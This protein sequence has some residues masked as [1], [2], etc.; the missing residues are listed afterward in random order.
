LAGKVGKL[1][2]I[3]YPDL[4]DDAP[5]AT[6]SKR[7][8]DVMISQT[9]TNGKV[10]YES[11]A[12]EKKPITKEEREAFEE[13]VADHNIGKMAK[14]AV[15]PRAALME[16]LARRGVEGFTVSKASSAAK[17]RN[18]EDY[19]SAPDDEDPVA[20]PAKKAVAKAAPAKRASLTGDEDEEDAPP[21]RKPARKTV[22]D[23]EDDEAPPSRRY[24]TADADDAP[25]D[26]E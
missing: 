15:Q 25:D 9:N 8:F 18:Y 22:L 21:A 12:G 23:E 5:D 1:S 17:K 13:Y 3:A 20:P 11:H 14:T 19:D 16:A 6:D 26:E 10:E 2:E 4:G 7:G 24:A